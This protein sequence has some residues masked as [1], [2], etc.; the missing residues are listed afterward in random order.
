MTGAVKDR[1]MKSNSTLSR[2]ALLTLGSGIVA[3][4]GLTGMH[5]V[6]AQSVVTTNAAVSLGSARL[7]VVMLRG[8]MDGLSL[9]APYGDNEYYQARANIAIARPGE[10]DGLIAL[11]PLHGLHPAFAPMLP[12]WEQKQL[13]FV[14]ASGSHD[15]TRSHFDAQD[16]MES[17]TPGRKTTPDG[18]LNRLSGVLAGPTA[19]STSQRLQALNLGPTMP[20][21]LSGSAAVA[22]RASGNAATAKSLIDQP[23]VAAAFAQIYADDDALG[24]TVREATASRR[25]IMDTLASDDPTADRGGLSL[26]GLSRD[27]ARLGELMARDARIRLS[28]FAVGGWDTH[29]N[30]GHGKGPL[31]NRFALLAQALDALAKN[32]G[33]RLN[34]TSILVLSEFGRTV[35]QN[36]SNGTD[37]G[38]GNVAMLLGGQVWGGSIYGEWPGL[39]SSARHEGRDL[40]ITTDFRDIVADVL[41]R[42]MRLTDAQLALVLPGMGQRRGVGLMG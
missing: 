11:T 15:P 26:N 25:E 30:Q 39:E 17:G 10:T 19:T 27:T 1:I 20:R 14:H 12:Y 13:A 35:K 21:I 29:A 16:Y 41:E 9:L 36:G 8:A 3:S 7:I 24:R 40:A 23:N 4:S 32:L 38:H 34:E 5:V 31:A 18:W 28:F 42:R 6:R 37:H 33:P 22:S 2:R